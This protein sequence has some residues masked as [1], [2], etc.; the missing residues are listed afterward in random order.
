MPWPAALLSVERIPGRGAASRSKNPLSATVRKRRFSGDVWSQWLRL[1]AGRDGGATPACAQTAG[2]G[3]A[4]RARSRMLF[5]ARAWGTGTC[6]GR[7]R[8]T[9]CRIPDAVP[10]NN[11]YFEST[12]SMSSNV[13]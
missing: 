3:D 5:R 12:S 4:R 2:S 8:H 10:L 1:T 6:R 9:T 7:Y 13:R 11:L